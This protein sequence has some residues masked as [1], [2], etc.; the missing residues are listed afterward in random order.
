MV[1]IE[2]SS[3]KVTHLQI[4][5]MAESTNNKEIKLELKRILKSG[6][7][8]DNLQGICKAEM[9]LKEEEHSEKSFLVSIEVTGDF[10]VSRVTT[11]SHDELRDAVMMELLPHLRACMSSAMAIAGLTPYLI[12]TSILSKSE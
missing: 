10:N 8:Q 3:V 1:L 5:N 4:I 2:M 11:I 12:P 6:E 9:F 7:A